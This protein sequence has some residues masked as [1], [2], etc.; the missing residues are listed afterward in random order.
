MKKLLVL[1]ITTLL[2]FSTYFSNLAYASDVDSHQMKHELNYWIA[3]DVIRA[4]A[5]GNYN[6]NKAVT[7]GEFASYITRAF[8]L[9]PS[10]KYK[11]NDL[12][13]NNSLT[14]EIQNAA[15]AGILSGYPDGSFK[16]NQEITRQQM[17]GM[18][19]KVFR[20]L[21]LPLEEVQ[22]TFKD[23][24]K[25]DPS[26]TKAVSA[27]VNLNIIRGSTEKAGVYFY[28]KR[29]ATIGHASAFLYRMVAAI[30]LLKPEVE[31]PTTPEIPVKPPVD[32]PVEPP[33]Y[34]LDTMVNGEI[35]K[36]NKYNSYEEALAK[37]SAGT[38]VITYND[39]IVKMNSGLASAADTSK[40]YTSIYSNKTLTN[41]I[42]YTTEGREM[43]YIGSGPDYVIVQVGGTIG[44]AKHSEVNLTPTQ[45]I[46][47][48]TRDRYVKNGSG[49]L[50]HYIYN[51]LTKKL[52][53]YTVGPAPDFMVPFTDYFSYDGVQFYDAKGTLKGTFYSYFQFQ[54]LRQ[55]TN[56]TAEELDSYIMNVLA[57]KEATK[58]ARYANATQKSK[59]IG[60]GTYL[61]EMEATY[62]VNAMFILA[63]AMHESDFGISNYAQT[64]NNLYGIGV[65]DSDPNATMYAK[66]ENS[67][68]AFV[69]RFINA[70][71]GLPSAKYANGLVP[72]NKTTGVNVRYAS[73]P[74][75]GAKIAGHMYRIDLALGSKD[76]QQATLAMT[77]S[78]SILNVRATPEVNSTN[79]LYTY[80]QKELGVNEAFGYPVV[81]VDEV[82]GTD[83][84][85]W[86]KVLSDTPP[87]ADY[88]W[89]RGDFLKKISY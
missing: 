23:A 49:M 70:N 74:Y 73:D 26:F 5:K 79:K 21:E 20:Y 72:G 50:N 17:A 63:A 42:T 58:I 64:I 32:P 59:L 33:T 1:A 24:A 69:T 14:I 38:Q 37:W 52:D 85:T 25:I 88:G 76:Y 61:K 7:R 44:Y 36:G 11:F 84:Y 83:G 27:N 40:N 13:A 31:E 77:T 30:E 46:T 2:I 62:R 81:I 15:G 34:R 89:I 35:I 4:D 53:Y 48:E 28:P 39:K 65:F 51:H 71:Y 29:N 10:T 16:P 82:Q 68:F 54:S 75:W 19:Y 41:E 12:K 22:L 67:V 60:L 78:N 18:L 43:K 8:E 66:P 47:E 86:Y 56:Y 87:P 57:E 9:P 3:K 55:T 45:A 6:P 80:A